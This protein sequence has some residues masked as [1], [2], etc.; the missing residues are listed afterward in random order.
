MD[1]YFI[2]VHF[3]LFIYLQEFHCTILSCWLLSPF[4]VTLNTWIMDFCICECTIYWLFFTINIQILIQ[5]LWDEAQFEESLFWFRALKFLKFKNCLNNLIF[6][7][8]VFDLADTLFLSS[9]S[10]TYVRTLWSYC[11]RRSKTNNTTL[12]FLP[13]CSSTACRDKYDHQSHYSF[14]WCSWRIRGK[15]LIR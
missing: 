14:I 2:L 3:Y 11:I 6:E 15:G 9:L 1:I 4:F 5:L 7:T 12:T 10:V 13:V 8:L